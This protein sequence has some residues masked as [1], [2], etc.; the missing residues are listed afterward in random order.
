MK[1][2]INIV[3]TCNTKLKKASRGDEG[4]DHTS[5]LLFK[6]EDGLIPNEAKRRI[7]AALGLLKLKRSYRPSWR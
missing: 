5:L 1:E 6:L 3:Q 4:P 7:D 2:K